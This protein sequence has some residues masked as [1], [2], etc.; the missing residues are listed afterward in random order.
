M[1][2]PWATISHFTAHSA[3]IRVKPEASRQGGQSPLGSGGLRGVTTE[4]DAI[5]MTVCS[6]N[7]LKHTVPAPGGDHSANALRSAC[8]DK[9]SLAS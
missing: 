8:A 3:V 4:G 1:V 9:E 7:A 6:G 2:F 5:A